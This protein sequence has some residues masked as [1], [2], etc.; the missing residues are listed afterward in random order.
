MEWEFE[1]EVRAEKRKKKIRCQREVNRG[2][3]NGIAGAA[4]DSTVALATSYQ[5]MFTVLT[6]LIRNKYD[7]Y[8][9]ERKDIPY[10]PEQAPLLAMRCEDSDIPLFL[11]AEF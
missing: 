8:G 11:R 2:R 10:P 4:T 6:I 5:L 3:N 9:A 1:V 7:S